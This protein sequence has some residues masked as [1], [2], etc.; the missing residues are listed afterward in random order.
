MPEPASWN[1]ELSKYIAENELHNSLWF[2]GEGPINLGA[3]FATKSAL[4]DAVKSWS[5]KLQRQ[6]RVLRSS[7]EVYTVVCETEGCNFRVH[8]H[9]PK[10]KSYWVVSTLKEHN[11]M[12][13]NMRSSHCN[14][15]AAYVANKYYKE[16]IEGDDIPVRHIIKLVENGCPLQAFYL[17]LGCYRQEDIMMSK[18][19]TAVM[20]MIGTHGV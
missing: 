3:M 12:L 10:Y 14:L 4:Q 8:A 1:R 7:K 9:V 16:I 18:K 15:S 19:L 13:R 6:F 17:S 5:L 11:C 20:D 2:Y